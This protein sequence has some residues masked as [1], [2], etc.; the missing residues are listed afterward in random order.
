[1]SVLVGLTD[2]QVKAQQ[3]AGKKNVEL[4]ASGRTYWDII[5][6]NL[7]SFFSLVLFSICIILIILGQ[8]QDAQITFSVGLVNALI[9]TLQE[10]RA[11]H[12]LDKISIFA[13]PRVVVLRNQQEQEIATTELVEGDVIRLQAGDQAVVDGKL[14]NSNM[15]EMDETLITGEADHIHKV[16]G[17][18]ILSGSFCISGDGYYRA[19]KVGEDCFANQLTVA[20][21]TF[22]PMQTPL[23]KQVNYI[24]RLIMVIALIMGAIFYIAG[25]VQGFT[26]LENIKATAVIT[27]LVPY[28]LF[29]TVAVT[30]ALGSAKIA[31]Q[32]ALV[33]QSNAVE[34]LHHVDVLCMDK[35]GTLTANRMLLDVIIPIGPESQERVASLIG[36]YSRS[37]SLSNSTNKAIIDGTTGIPLQPTSEIT[38]SSGRGWSAMAF[39]QP[40][41][42][43]TF[44]MGAVGSLWPFLDSD[45]DALIDELRET[46][47]GLVKQGYR[48]LLFASFDEVT[49]LGQGEDGGKLPKLTP[50]GLISLQNELRPHAAETL[51]EFADLG[52][53]LKILSG[54][55]PDTVA[56]LA[57]QAGFENPKA[58]SGSQLSAMEP[59]E[60]AETI[61]ETAIFGRMNPEQKQL[62]VSTLVEKDHYVAM[63][64]D[65]VNDV[66]SLKKANLGIAM[67]SGS[68]AT[69]NV[70]DM[71]LLDDSYAALIPALTQGKKM[72][73]GIRDAT[74]L[75]AARGLCYALVIIAVMMIG[76]TFPFE[77]S[78]LGLTAFSVGIPAFLLTLFAPAK[79]RDE[80]LLHSVL[81]FVLPFAVFTMLF[82]VGF[83][84][85]YDF[86]ITDEISDGLP[87]RLVERFEETTGLVYGVD[88]EFEEVVITFISQTNLSNFLSL[89]TML[90]ILFLYPPFQFFA[91]WRPV[92]PDKRPALMAIGL[93]IT[94]VLVL[95]LNVIQDRFGIVETPEWAWGVLAGVLAVW[96]IGFRFVLKFKL[97]EKILLSE[98]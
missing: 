95:E 89:A 68:N 98:D 73:N 39:D 19:D 76:L 61:E 17:D 96:F 70:A 78:Q 87:D 51:A 53:K 64:G 3:A 54:D 58:I 23:Q 15:L 7:F 2:Q 25:F 91:V 74:Y 10:I 46:A 8:W 37:A 29:L 52:I 86:E 49:S 45:Q 40:D 48:V 1:M 21:R 47:T 24:V 38:F 55:N 35:T 4:Q 56:A 5:H 69:R 31:Q 94:Y 83:Y 20:A 34:S 93:I 90:M 50:L 79:D 18:E 67:Q 77:P 27:G 63:I 36:R 43:G 88:A 85:Y 62:V 11:K 71:V 30:Y 16:V 41:M 92:T 14:L 9:G 82:A 13:L 12:Q 81:T 97:A 6:H 65:G 84:V 26:L 66:L 33:Q 44:A 72:V 32:G 59:D 22:E 57:K 60:L 28:G 42:S 80:S 75:L